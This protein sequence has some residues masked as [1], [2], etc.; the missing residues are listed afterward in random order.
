MIHYLIS[1]WVLMMKSSFHRHNKEPSARRGRWQRYSSSVV[2]LFSIYTRTSWWL[3][4]QAHAGA[5]GLD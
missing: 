5:L 4:F 2:T 3:L 1:G